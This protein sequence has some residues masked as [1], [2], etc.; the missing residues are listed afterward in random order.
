MSK[1]EFEL[2]EKTFVGSSGRVFPES[3]K[4]S[5]LLRAWLARLKNQNV[6]FSMNCFAECDF[7]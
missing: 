7:G 3:F 2:G 4:A 6:I 1:Y 5:P